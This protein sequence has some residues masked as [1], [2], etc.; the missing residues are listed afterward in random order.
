MVSAPEEKPEDTITAEEINGK[1]STEDPK[2]APWKNACK[3][4]SHERQLAKHD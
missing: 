2:R 3:I 4:T 1:A